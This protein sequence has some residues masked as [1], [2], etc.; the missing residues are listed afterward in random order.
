MHAPQE[1]SSPGRASRRPLFYALYFLI[2]ACPVIALLALLPRA[3]EYQRERQAWREKGLAL[4]QN[5]LAH[6]PPLV[7][8]QQLDQTATAEAGCGPIIRA[9]YTYYIACSSVQDYYQYMALAQGWTPT[10]TSAYHGAI[11]KDYTKQ[12]GEYRLILSLDCFITPEAGGTPYYT[13]FIKA[14]QPY[15]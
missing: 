13:L 6:L 11:V 8:S 14:P 12:D 2:L 1:T 4:I 7:G 9:H 5:E 3:Q 10:P 15:F